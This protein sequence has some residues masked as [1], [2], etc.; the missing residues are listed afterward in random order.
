MLRL[1]AVNLV[2]QM[3]LELSVKTWYLLILNEAGLT[4]AVQGGNKIL[5]AVFIMAG[6]III[7]L[8][9]K[10]PELNALHQV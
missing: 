3:L 4:S 8:I 10:T 5:Q 9:L 7:A 6:V 2:I 1:H